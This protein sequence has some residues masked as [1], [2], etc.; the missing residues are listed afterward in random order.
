MEPGGEGDRNRFG[1]AE[2]EGEGIEEHASVFVFGMG[3]RATV[4]VGK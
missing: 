2:D 4:E 3:D 1:G